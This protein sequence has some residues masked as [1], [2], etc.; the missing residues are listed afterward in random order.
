MIL[1]YRD[2]HGTPLVIRVPLGIDIETL[3]NNWYV[4][5]KLCNCG[6][7]KIMDNS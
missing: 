2:Y 4:I 6:E 1:L 5:M 7:L 3:K